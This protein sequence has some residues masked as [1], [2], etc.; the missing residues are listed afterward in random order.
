MVGKRK[1][2]ELKRKECAYC[3]LADKA[4]LRQRR[5][6][7]PVKNPTI[8]NGHCI[9]RLEAMKEGGKK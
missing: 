2:L 9:D 7:C 8:R 6:Y 1:T 4:K 5:D 3:P